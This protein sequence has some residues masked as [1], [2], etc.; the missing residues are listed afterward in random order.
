MR[1][2][3]AA[4]PLLLALAL[5]VR[6]SISVQSTITFAEDAK[7]VVFSGSLVNVGDQTAE[8]CLLLLESSRGEPVPIAIG[9]LDPQ[10]TNAWTA[11]LPHLGSERQGSFATVFRLC[12]TDPNG[13]PLHA[14]QLF[15]YSLGEAPSPPV[16]L[17]ISVPVRPIEGTELEGAK[18][19]LETA[20]LDGTA[21]CAVRLRPRAG[22]EQRPATLRIV[23]P[24][25]L[26]FADAEPND[27][28][29]SRTI[30]LAP[31][32]PESVPFSVTNRSA[33]A[34]S[35][36]SIGAIFESTDD[37]GAPSASVATLQLPIGSTPPDLRSLTDAASL[38][39]PLPAAV[40]IAIALVFL[41]LEVFH[42]NRSAAP[43]A[44]H[45]RSLET[46]AA[47]TVVYAVLV[48]E[49]RLDLVVAPGLCLGGDTP[50]HHY[51][52]SHLRESLAH[53]RIVSWAPGW[54][55][56]FPMYRFYFPL[57]YLAM[58][59]LDAILPAA[60]AFKVGLVLGV[61]L[62]PLCTYAAARLLR[63]R[64]PAPELLVL[65]TLPLL[66]DT[67]HTMWGVNLSSTLAGMIS[68]SWSFPLAL[69]SVV[70]DTLDARPR[71]RTVLL[72]L[73]V[74]LSHFFTSIVLALL[75]L[76]SFPFLLR[77]L[78]AELR[79]RVFR[80][81]ALDGLS[82]VF[83]MLWW[84]LPLVADR[85]W[86]VDYGDPWTIHF[87]ANLPVFAKIALGPVV[88]GSAWMLLRPALG[89]DARH[90]RL[91][92]LLALLQIAIA[93]VLFFF[94]YDI[95]KVFVNCRLWPFWIHGLLVASALVTA[96]ALRPA[97]HPRLAFLAFLVATLAFAWDPPNYARNY[98][99]WNFEGI[100]ARPDAL[101]FQDLVERL[102]GTPGRF[103]FDLHPDNVRFGSTR[104]FEALPALNGKSIVEGG[105]VNS[106]IGSL[107]AYSVQGEVSDSP[108]GWP[109]RVIPRRRDVPTGLRHLELLGVRH[110]LARSSFVQKGV[111]EDPAWTLVH[112]YGKWRLYENQAVD[113]SLVHAYPGGLPVVVT[114]DFQG[115]IIAWAN[116]PALAS[117]PQIVVESESPVGPDRRAGRDPESPKSEIRPTDGQTDG[118]T[119]KLTDGRTDRLT[120]GPTDR[121]TDRLTDRQTDR[122]TDRLTDRQTDRP[123]DRP[124][125]PCPCELSFNSLRFTTDRI[126]EPHLIAVSAFPNWRVLRGA[127]RIYLATPGFMVVFPN[128]PEVELAFAPTP[129]DWLGRVFLLPGFLLLIF[130]AV[131]GR[132]KDSAYGS[133][134]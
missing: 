63:L 117:T 60:I 86:S 26:A 35:R 83:L 91:A 87:F 41:L 54:W 29:A 2:L 106:A 40:P 10:A 14:V 123:T 97:R 128:G 45:F 96:A 122:P 44:P 49:L 24:G 101:V 107:V 124:T 11:A 109:L 51:L 1:L 22:T 47:F 7:G 18:P 76:A 69:A 94:G 74:L 99:K 72:L 132:S 79:L 102:R 42:R 20:P 53:G 4:A 89:E 77:G 108:A 30:P 64:R 130:I 19:L 92:L 57:P 31:P 28:A 131:Q 39:R 111:E 9:H 118:P 43:S 33:L 70:R 88:V 36:I 90:L 126:G 23:L 103:A 73:A 34:G 58:V 52:F 127:D 119:D 8:D 55:C 78:P 62:T 133:A 85:P 81:F 59:L 12:Y 25:S 67:T 114:N 100:E 98:A 104:A 5:P 110:F 84:L 46:I 121:P 50:A 13:F 65:A 120:D 48:Y 37:D 113:G 82:A 66:L 6:A 105:I 125:I 16:R 21:D 68:N 115:A 3:S 17:E 56:G 95:S 80:A 134:Q 61:F 129:V 27:D 116:K 32:Y 15:P 75:L 93:L 38:R 71:I 112:D